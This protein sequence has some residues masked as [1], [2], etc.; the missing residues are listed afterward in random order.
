MTQHVCDRCGDIA[1]DKFSLRL[2]QFIDRK[3]PE[4]ESKNFGEF[5]NKCVGRI[6]DF[7]V[8]KPPTDRR[9]FPPPPL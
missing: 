8:T 5:C 2:L 7:E 6:V 4:I 1:E 9:N 3:N